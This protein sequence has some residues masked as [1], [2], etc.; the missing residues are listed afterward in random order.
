MPGS[1]FPL[2]A[3]GD[4]AGMLVHSPNV[5][6]FPIVLHL[7]R[8]LGGDA[9]WVHNNT[10]V[11]FRDTWLDPRAGMIRL[12]GIV[13]CAIDRSILHTLVNVARAWSPQRYED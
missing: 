3:T 4:F 9:V 1:I 12:P 13:A 5:Y 6:D 11:H 2:L 7:A 10:P 8:L